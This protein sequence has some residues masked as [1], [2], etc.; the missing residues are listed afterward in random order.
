VKH[1]AQSAPE[2][3][4]SLLRDETDDESVTEFLEHA[5][6]WGARGISAHWDVISR[7]FVG[8]A[9]DHGLRVYSMTREL[10]TV[11][12]KVQA[13]LAGIVTDHPSEVKKILERSGA[14]AEGLLLPA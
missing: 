12:D 2:I 14:R 4:V 1:T 6:S 9:E 11:A 7:D 5:R 8:E 13:G 3:E 10:R